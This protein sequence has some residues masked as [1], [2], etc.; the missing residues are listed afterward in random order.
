MSAPSSLLRSIFEPTSASALPF[1][2]RVQHFSQIARELEV[3]ASQLLG[4]D[5]TEFSDFLEIT[6][7]QSLAGAL[8]EIAS[9]LRSESSNSNSS[10][11]SSSSEASRMPA[12][13]AVAQRSRDY[14]DFADL[15]TLVDLVAER[16]LRRV[17]RGTQSFIELHLWEVQDAFDV[18]RQ[19]FQIGQDV[20]AITEEI[21][22][23]LERAMQ[24]LD[25]SPQF[26]DLVGMKRDLRQALIDFSTMVGDM[27][28]LVD[29]ELIRQFINNVV[30]PHRLSPR[31][32]SLVILRLDRALSVRAENRLSHAFGDAI[33]LL[34]GAT[35]KFDF[36]RDLVCDAYPYLP[37]HAQLWSELASLMIVLA[38]RPN[39]R[40]ENRVSRSICLRSVS[41]LTEGRSEEFAAAV[42]LGAKALRDRWERNYLDLYYV[43]ASQLAA[44][45]K[46]GA[47]LKV[48]DQKTE[49]EPSTAALL[50]QARSAVVLGSDVQSRRSLFKIGLSQ[51][52][53]LPRQ[54]ELHFYESAL[55]SSDA[56]LSVALKDLFDLASL[57]LHQSEDIS[58]AS[59]WLL[60]QSVGADV[61]TKR[62]LQLFASLHRIFDEHVARAEMRAQLSRTL[63]DSWAKNAGKEIDALAAALSF[64]RAS[65]QWQKGEFA[66]LMGAFEPSLQAVSAAVKI[67]RIAPALADT[68]STAVLKNFPEYAERIGE[69]GCAAT[70]R[71]NFFTLLRL[72]QVLGGP[73]AMPK[74]TM[75]WWWLSTIGVYLR[76][77]DQ[78]VMQGNLRALVQ[79]LSPHLSVKEHLQC[80]EILGAVYRK[81]LAIDIPRDLA[82]GEILNFRLFTK[83]GP[84]WCE[85]FA[86]FRVPAPHHLSLA[87]WFIGSAGEGDTGRGT[88]ESS[89][90]Q[91]I[92]TR[93][94]ANWKGSG[95]PF[96]SWSELAPQFAQAIRAVGAARLQRA[97][98][99]QMA[100]LDLSGERAIYH[101]LLIR[102]LEHLQLTAF[103]AVLKQRA[104]ALA[105]TMSQLTFQLPETPSDRAA[106]FAQKGE[107]DLGLLLKTLADACLSI[108][109]GIAGLNA[110]RFLIECILP[111]VRYSALSWQR[112]WC[113]AIEELMPDLG[114]PEA[115]GAR[116][117]FALLAAVTH[118][119][120]AFQTIGQALFVPSAPIFSDDTAQEL[121]WR[122]FLGGLLVSIAALDA[123]L[124]GESMAQSLALAAPLLPAK[125]ALSFWQD[126]KT[127][128]RQLLAPMLSAKLLSACDNIF[129]TVE[130]TLSVEQVFQGAPSSAA[131]DIAFSLRSANPDSLLLWRADRLTR[132]RFEGLSTPLPGDLTVSRA[133]GWLCPDMVSFRRAI[134]HVTELNVDTAS[135]LQMRSDYGIAR[136]T[137]AQVQQFLLGIARIALH[138]AFLRE[139][140]PNLQAQSLATSLLNAEWQ[141]LDFKVILDLAAAFAATLNDNLDESA[142]AGR[143][144]EIANAAWLPFVAINAASSTL[145]NQLTSAS[146]Q[147]AL[148]GIVLQQLTAIAGIELNL[149]ARQDVLAKSVWFQSLPQTMRIQASSAL[150]RTAEHEVS[151]A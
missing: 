54:G 119:A 63:L 133:T 19:R 60:A 77:R 123:D 83:R 72:A 32:W 39:S 98:I 105:T 96:I 144:G 61:S 149:A 30:I 94:D 93:F 95:D 88:V 33:E 8:Q 126:A 62:Q 52:L 131:L 99:T 120:E 146:T 9:A 118:H 127:P 71:D 147:H 70:R 31:I 15:F 75:I 1:R 37:P 67:V 69:N 139:G 25:E 109:Q 47:D 130:R 97:W 110:A 79:T 20:D 56:S 103:G 89:Y 7:A 100:G 22:V 13:V 53:I 87:Q 12:W 101:L 80:A 58:P 117:C 34:L 14:V 68:A 28:V 29:I 86:A 78:P 64:L 129:K 142:L 4:A 135:Q 11:S 137:T 102:G 42:R 128:L 35:Q 134:A 85:A 55:V 113:V 124:P 27:G 36:L 41:A 23:G 140:V 3:L 5:L 66:Q 150:R 125:N 65:A 115:A 18:F 92:W 132:V 40:L 81:G 2:L 143:V 17:D 16:I 21:F 49:L 46:A 24:L 48:L 91:A 107:R 108:D 114:A 43:A 90:V 6:D 111:N 106:H 44:F 141:Q 76:N 73:N 59:V 104:Q 145:G 84:L 136:L 116:R 82:N 26:V 74:D 112:I 57:D 45:S 151:H 10:S 121:D 50:A 38:S 51:L 138:T 148:T 122:S